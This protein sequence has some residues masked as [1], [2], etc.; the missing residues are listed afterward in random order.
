[1]TALQALAL[2]WLSCGLLVSNRP[3]KHKSHHL[4][5]FFY[6]NAIASV[7][8]SYILRR[9][10]HNNRTV[11]MAVEQRVHKYVKIRKSANDKVQELADRKHNGNWHAAIHQIIEEYKA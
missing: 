10:T 1:M 4:M 8:L 11:N 3:S 9:Y 5:A 7:E 6:F 2:V